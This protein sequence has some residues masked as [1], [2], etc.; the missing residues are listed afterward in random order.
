ML[1]CIYYQKT[2]DTGCGKMLKTKIEEAINRLLKEGDNLDL[3]HDK[4]TAKHRRI[5]MTKWK[6]ATWRGQ[7]KDKPFFKKL[8]QKTGCLITVN[9]TD[10][11][12]VEPQGL[13]GY[14]F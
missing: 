8:F 5:L 11:D 2:I 6:A 3:W 7:R 4:L 14:E 10:D 9:G 1:L 12:L 13:D